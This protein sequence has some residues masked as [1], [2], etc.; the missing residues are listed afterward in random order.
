MSQQN[1]STTLSQQQV[2]AD[3]ADAL[4]VSPANLS[5]DEDLF[6]AGLDSIRLM[7]LIEKW[8]TAGS[9][10]ADFPTLAAEPALGPWIKV[11]L[12]ADAPAARAEQA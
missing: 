10:G 9:A 2:V 8:R 4:G 11:I 1:V 12:G 6:D 3:I 5:M 7:S